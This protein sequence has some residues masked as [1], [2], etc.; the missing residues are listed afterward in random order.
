MR[1]N[2][3]MNLKDIREGLSPDEL[4]DSIEFPPMPHWEFGFQRNPMEKPIFYV[5]L[6]ISDIDTRVH[7][8]EDIRT[9]IK[10]IHTRN[11]DEDL[12]Q[13]LLNPPG[14]QL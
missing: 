7:G 5:H 1:K 10:T 6:S 11:Y 14:K 3:D 13:K 9:S 2:G 8:F 4:P 12:I